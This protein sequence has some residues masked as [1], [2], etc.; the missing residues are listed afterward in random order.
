MSLETLYGLLPQYEGVVHLAHSAVE[1]NSALAHG[2]I[3]QDERDALL[4][5]LANTHGIVLAAE[6]QNQ[7]LFAEQVLRAL[8]SLPIPS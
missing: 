5:D 4:V 7:R 6:E 2:D 8:A 3:T 1:I